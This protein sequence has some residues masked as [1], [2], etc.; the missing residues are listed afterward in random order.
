MDAGW[1]HG[2]NIN[3]KMTPSGV[4]Y[5]RPARPTADF[6]CC[7][8]EVE[9]GKGGRQQQWFLQD[10]QARDVGLGTAGIQGERASLMQPAM[11][12]PARQQSSHDGQ[13]GVPPTMLPPSR[14][15]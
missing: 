2:P 1:L 7:P 5:R 4:G 13:H 8:A 6:R 3:G 9:F 12:W 15:L 11:P 14:R 10:M